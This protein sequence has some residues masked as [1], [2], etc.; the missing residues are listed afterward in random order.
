MCPGDEDVQG[1]SPIMKI[2]I[3]A[4]FPREDSSRIKTDQDARRE[5]LTHSSSRFLV[6]P[7]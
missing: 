6:L 3:T 2:S 4:F 7:K 1:A 5:K